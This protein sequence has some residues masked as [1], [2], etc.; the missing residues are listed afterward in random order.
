[1][2]PNQI[3]CSFKFHFLNNSLS[4]V[5]AGYMYISGQTQRRMCLPPIVD[6]NCHYLLGMGSGPG[7]S[8]PS[9]RILDGLVLRGL[10]QATTLAVSY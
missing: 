5:S 8:F 1:M 10:T 7:Y 6:I 2:S 3:L 9:P 4:T